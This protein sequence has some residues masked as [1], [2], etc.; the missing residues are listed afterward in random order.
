MF[1]T[2]DKDL[3]GFCWKSANFKTFLYTSKIDDQITWKIGN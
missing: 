3:N 2:V 1:I